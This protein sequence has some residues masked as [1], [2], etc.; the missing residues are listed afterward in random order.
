MKTTIRKRNSILAGIGLASLLVY[1]L[2]C[3]STSFSPDDRKVLFPAF[4][5]NHQGISA[6]VYNRKSHKT[7]QIYTLV[8]PVVPGKTNDSGELLRADWAPDGKHVLVA[9]Q[10]DGLSLTLVPYGVQEPVRQ[11]LIPK[12]EVEDGLLVWPLH[13]VG[14]KVFLN[15][16]NHSLVAVDMVT[17]AT[18]SNEFTND[19]MLWSDAQ[20]KTLFALTE[21]DNKSTNGV[22]GRIDPETL[23][24][25]PQ[26]EFSTALMPEGGTIAVSTDGERL[27]FFG[28]L[29]HGTNLEL[30][31]FR[32]GKLEF[33]RTVESD[34]RKI[35]FGTF[36]A[37]S[38]KGD[39]LYTSFARRESGAKNSEYGLLEIPLKNDPARWTTLARATKGDDADAL[40]FQGGLSHDGRTWAVSS[41][42]LWAANESFAASDCALFLVDLSS[43]DRKVTKV[44]IPTP[45]RRDGLLKK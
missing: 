43:R 17:G 13:M 32:G 21:P 37:L 38:P 35:F 2:A 9:S 20:G 36:G 7:E 10:P 30:R 1:V 24:L 8:K 15:G 26:M 11:L 23:A 25:Q 45:Q 44:P 14:S 40:F 4:D 27:C 42:Y 28:K 18:R 16:K 39:C 41:A 31:V 22:F 12:S 29:E 34:E 6:M 33:S 5:V 3:S 19:V